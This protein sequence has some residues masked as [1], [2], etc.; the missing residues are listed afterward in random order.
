MI[1]Y[2]HYKYAK[3]DFMGRQ[4]QYLEMIAVPYQLMYAFIEVDK[5]SARTNNVCFMYCCKLNR[6]AVGVCT[7]KYQTF[8]LNTLKPI[9]AMS[10]SLFWIMNGPAVILLIMHMYY[11]TYK[12][13]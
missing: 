1:T 4:T 7:K 2:I 10:C 13:I 8:Y 5:Y 11:H 3:Y 6:S 9:F 12:H